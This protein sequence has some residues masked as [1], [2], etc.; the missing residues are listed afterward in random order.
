MPFS[1]NKLSLKG[2]GTS[3]IDK[4]VNKESKVKFPSL[5]KKKKSSSLT[6]SLSEESELESISEYSSVSSRKNSVSES[7]GIDDEL[8]DIVP[9]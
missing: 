6:N 1:N 9:D 3:L 7:I 5:K 4:K 8:M 2:S